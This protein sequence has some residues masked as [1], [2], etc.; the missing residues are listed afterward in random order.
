MV[1]GITDTSKIDAG[2][3][4]S[5]AGVPAGATVLSVDSGTQITLSTN[6]TASASGVSLTFEDD[7]DILL[8]DNQIS[9][10]GIIRVSSGSITEGNA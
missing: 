2:M 4:V 3:Q 5:G 1:A 6:A 7:A 9:S 8:N 10:G